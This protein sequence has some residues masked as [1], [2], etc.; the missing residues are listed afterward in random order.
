[1]AMIL[2]DETHPIHAPIGDIRQIQVEMI[3]DVANAPT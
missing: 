2:V 3:V 1:M